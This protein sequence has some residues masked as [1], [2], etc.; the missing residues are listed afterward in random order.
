[1]RNKAK[2]WE[3]VRATSAASS[4]FD[5]ITIDG[6]EFVDGATGA[7]NPLDE[8]WTEATDTFKTDD[9]WTLEHNIQCLVS[10][11]TGRPTFKAFNE[12]I[13][14]ITGTLTAIATDTEKVW[15]NFNR[16]HRDMVK[17]LRV[18]RFNVDRGLEG[19]ELDET[20]SISTIRSA[21]DHYLQTEKVLGDLTNCGENVA[22]H[23]S[24]L[25][26]N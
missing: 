17:N 10:I 6:L 26:F 22:K 7:N 18:F 15:E 4:F 3:A 24:A 16:Q 12:N 25:Q 11:G 23:N 5:P 19:I 21:T 13:S 1:M 20:K 9:Q 14:K 2:L 8:L